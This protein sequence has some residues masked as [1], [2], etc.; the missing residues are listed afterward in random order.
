M[1][2]KLKNKPVRNFC[3]GTNNNMETAIMKYI[4]KMKMRVEILLSILLYLQVK[5]PKLFSMKAAFLKNRAV[6]I[7]IFLIS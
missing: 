5:Y 6:F 7:K 4:T 3:A 1:P 2:V